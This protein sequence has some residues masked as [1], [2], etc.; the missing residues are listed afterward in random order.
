MWIKLGTVV[1]VLVVAAVG[2]AGLRSPST[3]KAVATKFKGAIVN[4]R[5]LEIMPLLSPTGSKRLREL[6]LFGLP[7][8]DALRMLA[9]LLELPEEQ[10]RSWTVLEALDATA[11]NRDRLVTKGFDL[12]ADWDPEQ[13]KVSFSEMKIGTPAVDGDRASVPL[14]NQSVRTFFLDMEKV[15]DR[16][17]I[18]YFREPGDQPLWEPEGEMLFVKAQKYGWRSE[19]K[20]NLRN[21]AMAYVV[22]ANESDRKLKP[23]NQRSFDVLG[24]APER[25][26][27]Y[28][29]FLADTGPMELRPGEGAAPAGAWVIGHDQTRVGDRP[30]PSAFSA[31]NCPVTLTPAD[32]QAI[33]YLKEAPKGVGPVGPWHFVAAAVANFD[34]DPDMDC[35]SVA[36]FDRIAADGESISAN[37]PYLEQTD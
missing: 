10:V 3:P 4:Q 37:H 14:T 8:R 22:Y 11:R 34:A 26:N 31:T 32:P 24:F 23:P 36:T 25:G 5:F 30:A 7:P 20:H 13:W 17:M 1:A 16:W 15:G 2:A 35:W 6:S 12:G 33:N 9:D 27:R 19:A 18:S 21:L 29:Y 28:T